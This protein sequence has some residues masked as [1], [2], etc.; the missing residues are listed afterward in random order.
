MTVL[1]QMSVQASK[2]GACSDYRLRS[3][4]LMGPYAFST[5]LLSFTNLEDFFLVISL[6]FSVHV[7]GFSFSLCNSTFF[8]LLFRSDNMLFTCY[9]RPPGTPESLGQA[10]SQTGGLLALQA[11]CL[12]LTFGSLRS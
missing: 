6:N 3:T 7:W 11:L 2:P 9:Q 4:K 1:Q 5:Y 12:I 10:G 8:P